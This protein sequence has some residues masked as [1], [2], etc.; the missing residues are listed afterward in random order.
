[1]PS[2]KLVFFT[3]ICLTSALHILYTGGLTYSV[4]LKQNWNILW[5]WNTTEKAPQNS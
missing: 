3:I 1:M 5:R 4:V 2:K